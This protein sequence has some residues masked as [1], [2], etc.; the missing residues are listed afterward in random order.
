MCQAR[1]SRNVAGVPAHE[2]DDPDTVDHGSSLSIGGTQRLVGQRE[3]SLE[4]ESAVDVVNVVVDGFGQADD[5]EGI[6]IFDGFLRQQHGT[7]L[8]AVS[9]DSK[10]HVDTER[11]QELQFVLDVLWTSRSAQI[12][13]AMQMDVIDDLWR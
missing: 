8:G 1:Q 11:F 10:Q 3:G 4:T 5:G 12:S 9:T 13:A 6:T 2:L 7:S